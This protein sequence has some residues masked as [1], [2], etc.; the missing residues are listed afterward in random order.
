MKRENLI[1]EL[2]PWGLDDSSDRPASGCTARTQAHAEE[3]LA[4]LPDWNCRSA[5]VDD[6]A[7]DIQ[8]ALS[9]NAERDDL[10]E[11]FDGLV[12]TLGVVDLRRLVSVQRRL[13]LEDEVIDCR[14]FHDWTARMQ[15]AL[16]HERNSTFERAWRTSGLTLTSENPDLTVRWHT[17]HENDEVFALMVRHGSPFMEVGC[18]RGRWFLRDG[19]HRA[20]RLL[21]AGIFEI[22]AVIV[23]SA[24]L[25]ELGADQP[26]FFPEEVLFSRRPPLV[27]DFL[28]DERVLRW[29]RPARRKVIRISITEDFEL[30]NSEQEQGAEL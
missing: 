29:Y 3:T 8:N 5:R 14:E 23:Q 17:T 27:T 13:V 2:V 9:C 12:W 24:N 6:I 18:Y 28:A 16:P 11:E 19:Y 25:H 30:L 15:V 20:Y 7:A 1:L 26:W 10:R 4:S 22:P 21:R